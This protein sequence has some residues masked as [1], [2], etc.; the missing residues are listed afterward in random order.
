MPLAIAAYPR[1]VKT[2]QRVID[3]E[4]VHLNLPYLSVAECILRYLTHHTAISPE[5]ALEEEKNIQ[6]MISSVLVFIRFPGWAGK[7]TRL[8]YVLWE[9][10][11]SGIVPAITQLREDTQTRDFV[12]PRVPKAFRT[13]LGLMNEELLSDSWL[14]DFWRDKFDSIDEALIRLEALY[15]ANDLEAVDDMV[16]VDGTVV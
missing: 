2:F 6:D 12:S 3:H 14:G 7:R 1:T 9:L 5:D 8:Q 15:D 13:L 4:N 16:D 10:H 11:D